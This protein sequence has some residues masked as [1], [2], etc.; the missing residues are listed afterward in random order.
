MALG[1]LFVFTAANVKDKVATATVV[2]KARMN[3]LVFIMIKSVYCDQYFEFY[4][5][6]TAPAP[7]EPNEDELGATS[8]SVQAV[9][10]DALTRANKRM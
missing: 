3:V 6:S 2:T 1:L 8:S 9:I 5:G 10:A 7:P 4:K